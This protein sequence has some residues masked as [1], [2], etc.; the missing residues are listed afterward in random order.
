MSIQRGARHHKEVLR[1]RRK[2]RDHASGIGVDA[3]CI[4]FFPVNRLRQDPKPCECDEPQNEPVHPFAPCHC[5]TGAFAH[6]ADPSGV[7]VRLSR[8]RRGAAWGLRDSGMCQNLSARQSV[9]KRRIT[10]PFKSL[11]KRAAI[12]S[13]LPIGAMTV[14]FAARLFLPVAATANNAVVALAFG[15]DFLPRPPQSPQLITPWLLQ[16]AQYSW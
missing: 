7:N 5:A 14:A 12:I 16:S 11:H 2:E 1:I 13:V 6:L 4:E 9:T 15:V 8:A 10:T 3:Q